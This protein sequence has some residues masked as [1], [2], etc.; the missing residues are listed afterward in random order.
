MDGGK[1]TPMD[2]AAKERV[3]SSAGK[4]TGG[5]YEK[6]SWPATG[7]AAADKNVNASKGDSKGSKK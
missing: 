6:G 7:Q 2:D 1:K 4:E 3:M 5:Q